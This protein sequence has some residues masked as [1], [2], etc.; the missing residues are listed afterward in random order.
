MDNV[1]ATKLIKELYSKKK[2]KRQS[3]RSRSREDII[4]EAF[5]IFE[6]IEGPKNHF[7]VNTLLTFCLRFKC[8]D[9]IGSVW[10]D[11]AALCEHSRSLSDCS[12]LLV[13]CCIDS[14]DIARFIE[15]LSWMKRHGHSLSLH[16]GHTAKLLHSA[17]P[18]VAQ[19]KSI[20]N[21]MS[22]GVL[23]QNEYLQ[24]ALIKC[25]GDRHDIPS[26]LTLYRQ[27]MD[28][29]QTLHRITTN[30]LLMAM[31]DSGFNAEVIELYHSVVAHDG[32]SSSSTPKMEVD[33]MTHSMA[34][35]A[36]TNLRDFDRGHSIC[37][38]V[39]F[40]DLNGDEA[41][42]LKTQ[43]IDFYGAFGDAA[44]ALLVFESIPTDR[45]DV[46]CVGAVF[47]VL[48]NNDRHSEAVALYDALS[49]F[50][51]VR[52][53]D[54]IHCLV[55][56][57]C[58]KGMEMEKGE[59][60]WSGLPV[61]ERT[62]NV[63]TAFID[64][65][66]HCLCIDRAL[67][68]FHSAPKIAEDIVAVNAM[69]SA[70][71][72][73]GHY[74]DALTLYRA[75]SIEKSAASHVLALTACS[76]GLCFESGLEIYSEI[77]RRPSMMQNVQV[78]TASID[79]FG[80]SGDIETALRIFE[81]VESDKM[82]IVTINAMMKAF[83]HS[84]C[85]EKA[86]ALFDG[87]EEHDARS[88]SGSGSGGIAADHLTFS[89]AIKSCGHLVDR[90]NGERIFNLIPDRV[91]RA[92][93]Q[94][95]TAMISLYGQCG[96][97]ESARRQFDGIEDDRKSTSTINAMLSALSHN[98]LD[99]EALSLFEA[100]DTEYPHILKDDVLY[101]AAIKA[102]TNS[103][104]FEIGQRIHREI[105]ARKRTA[106]GT[107]S[108]RRGSGGLSTE[109]HLINMYSK[110]GMVEAAQSILDELRADGHPQYFVDIA[111]WN[112]MLNAHL[113]N[114][115]VERAKGVVL[116]MERETALRPN[117]KTMS[118][119]LNGCSHCGD[120]EGATRLWEGGMGG[121]DEMKYDSVV[122]GTL[123]DCSARGGH[124]Y[125]AFEWIWRYEKRRKQ[126]VLRE[127]EKDK[128][129]AMWMALLHGCRQQQNSC[130]AKFVY[131][132]IQQRFKHNP[133]KIK[134]ADV[135]WANITRQRM[136]KPR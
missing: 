42:I 118:L 134:S 4:D 119:L 46:V 104:R 72:H 124:L 49:R 131:H 95:E 100:M 60:I 77:G 40:R 13:L 47:K 120:I 133:A 85:P 39:D 23:P 28:S 111:L 99:L 44:T 127:E 36:C 66:G 31:V 26:A 113:R 121:D 82:N 76:K 132:G 73:C 10:A 8:P 56:K 33:A 14:V 80:S 108:G 67:S 128:D 43:M 96:D 35:R 65:C 29:G 6:S 110:C 75:V 62:L 64:L 86:L 79:L 126:P 106:S 115:D 51:R 17:H 34:L 50:P 90:Q 105:A 38:A 116:R 30:T 112:E 52:A 135:L 22:D 68:V 71:I 15:L 48:V 20:E 27:S 25:Y 94:I 114:G 101:S 32:S 122:I 7:S 18:T 45:V 59:A 37:S 74:D 87:I 57:A 98:G 81:S 12:S 103:G 70:L 41:L 3:E 11:I 130:L 84:E 125:A 53:D 117:H 91:K 123:V 9:R 63:I 69:L 89:M 58:S 5:Q 136:N 21:A 92:N 24:S 54:G 19:L 16:I 55:L 109:C 2:G 97:V 61:E 102:A 93:V 83:V 88:R 129:Y 1:L 107:V 78:Q